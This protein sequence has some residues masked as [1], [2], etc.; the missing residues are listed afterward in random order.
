MISLVPSVSNS[1][2]KPLEVVEVV[3][4]LE[5]E[6][7]VHFQVVVEAHYQKEEVEGGCQQT[8]AEVR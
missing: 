3:D 1:D 5:E 8:V 6:E 2:L 4:H 7:V